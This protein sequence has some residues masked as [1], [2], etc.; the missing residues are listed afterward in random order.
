MV[1]KTLD[2]KTLHFGNYYSEIHLKVDLSKGRKIKLLSKAWGLSLYQIWVERLLE[3][4]TVV[5]LK[6]S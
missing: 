3:G 1:T 4:W 5:R 2:K 6:L